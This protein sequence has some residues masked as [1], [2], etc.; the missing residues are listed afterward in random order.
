M[1]Y[2]SSKLV[3]CLWLEFI[4][5]SVQAGSQVA[6]CSSYDWYDP[7]WQMHTHAVTYRDLLPRYFIS[8]A[9]WAKNDRVVSATVILPNASKKK[10]PIYFLAESSQQVWE[11][12]D[13]VKIKILK[14]FNG[15]IITVIICMRNNSR[16]FWWYQ[17]N[18]TS[19]RWSNS[20]SCLGFLHLLMSSVTAWDTRFSKWWRYLY[21]ML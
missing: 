16:E 2:K 10:P 12:R 18:W 21:C 6:V 13:P 17:S 8:S 20:V 11:V 4:S 3:F 15:C 5:R 19:C 7:D 14:P 9:S 1:T